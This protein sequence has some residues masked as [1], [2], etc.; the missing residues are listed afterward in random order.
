MAH[1]CKKCK[2]IFCFQRKYCVCTFSSD[3]QF[4]IYWQQC[5]W[6]VF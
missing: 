6:M 1:L 2:P 5:H 3:E 4:F